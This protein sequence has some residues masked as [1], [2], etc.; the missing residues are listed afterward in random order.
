M[1]DEHHRT[2]TDVQGFKDL[3]KGEM[4]VGKEVQE[5]FSKRLGDISGS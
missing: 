3:E 2:G 1:P 5:G 4:I